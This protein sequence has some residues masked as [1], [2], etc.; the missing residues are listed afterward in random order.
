M[1]TIKLNFKK[2]QKQDK[3]KFLKFIAVEIP[4]KSVLK[5]T[6]KRSKSLEIVQKTKI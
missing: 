3:T 4:W 1:I 2:R 5:T 6:T